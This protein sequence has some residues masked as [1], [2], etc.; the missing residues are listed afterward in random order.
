MPGS[1]DP[2]NLDYGSYGYGGAT[3]RITE[4]SIALNPVQMG[5]R[6]YLASVGI[7]TSRDP[8]PGGNANAYAYALDPI[9]GNDFSG[10]MSCG[11][12]HGVAG[13]FSAGEVG[14]MQSSNGA[15]SHLQPNV[16]Q[17]RITYSNAQTSHISVPQ[18]RAAAK[19]AYNNSTAMARATVSPLAALGV[20]SGGSNPLQGGMQIADHAAERMAG[21]RGDVG[22]TDWSV[23]YILEHGAASPST[24]IAGRTV[25][26]VEDFGRIVTEEDGTLVTA[27]P[28]NR[29]A[30]SGFQDEYLE[31]LI[32]LLL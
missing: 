4:T 28:L 19:P 23:R 6:V 11:N 25:Y 1:H 16:G 10:N 13:C 5:A 18:A 31:L 9:N 20:T 15:T 14:A 12:M 22:M 2:Q 26:E 29:M 3:Q 17:S 21:S 8:V 24:S 7:F 27:I 32:L 30:G